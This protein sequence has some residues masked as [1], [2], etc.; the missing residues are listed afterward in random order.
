MEN[1]ESENERSKLI[2]L[3]ALNNNDEFIISLKI[4]LKDRVICDFFN[5]N[6]LNVKIS[7][8][9]I[10]VIILI[11][12]V[13]LIKTKLFL[14]IFYGGKIFYKNE[15]ALNLKTIKRQIKNYRNQIKINFEEAKEF[16]KRDK[17]KISLII[18]VCNQ[19]NFITYAY[20]FI[21][22]QNLKDLEIIFIDDASIDNSCTLIKKL[23]KKD[24]RIIYI[25]NKDNKGSFY[26]RNVGVL[27]SK[28]EYIL[29]NDP[30]DFLL[31]DILFK[32]YKISKYY[33]LDILQY[34]AIKGSYR[35]N[36]IWRKNQYKSGILYEDK[37]KD[38]FFYSIT[39]TLWD[40]LIKKDVFI[41]GINYM[42]KEFLTEVYFVHSDDTIFWGIINFAKSYGFLEQIG[43]FYNYNNPASIVHHY[44]D[45]KY[46][47][48]I[49][50]SLFATLK[51]YYIQTKDNEE[52]KNYVGYQFF[53]DKVYKYYMNRTKELTHGIHFIINV[54]DM[55]INCSFFNMTQKLNF[56][57]FRNTII[58][59]KRK[60]KINKIIH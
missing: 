31:N 57:Y 27:F 59:M 14:D 21:Q 48:K 47:N 40:K 42:K 26:S 13:A 7:C 6:Y 12:F 20:S 30:D 2:S 3:K 29:I 10:L 38:V 1:K 25:N 5:K 4:S 11:F 17:S 36:D 28:G 52:E 45:S 16:I 60:K 37:V 33:N 56:I 34:Y 19:R 23:M 9:I 39:R 18:T 46:I 51:Y 43:Y 32:A 8:S 55:Y 53:Y 41:K 15:K 54:I 58:K 22:K 24:K 49:F 44:H 50:H 35:D